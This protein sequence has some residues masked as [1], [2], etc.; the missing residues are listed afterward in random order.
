[1]PIELSAVLAMVH[2]AMASWAYSSDPPRMIWSTI[3]KPAGVVWL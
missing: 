2:L 3:T 1:M